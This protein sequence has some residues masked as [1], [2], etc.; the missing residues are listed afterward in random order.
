[1]IRN[2]LL[3]AYRNTIKTKLFSAINIFGLSIGMTA[4]LL[5]LHYVTFEKSYDKFHDNYQN[6][7]R[8]RYER[9]TETS[10]VRF[11][12]CCPPAAPIIRERYPE[13]KK[14]G[15]MVRNQATVS[16]GDKKMYEERMFYAEPEILEVLNFPFIEGDPIAGLK[17]PGNAVISEATSKRYFGSENPMGK[18][19]SVDKKTDYQIVGVF[20]DIPANSHIKF[21]ILLPWENLFK[22]LGTDYTEAWGHTGS[23]TYLALENGYSGAKFEKK[24]AGLVDELLGEAL[25]EYKMTL[26]LK[27]QPLADIHLTSNYLQEY[28]ANGNEDVVNILLIIA[29]FLI[30]MAWVNYI[31]LS[32]ARSLNRAKEVGLRKVVGASRTNLTIQFFVETALLNLISLVAAICLLYLTVPYFNSITGMASEI[33]IWSQSWFIPAIILLF[34]TG[35]ILSGFYPV[36][37]LS[38]FRPAVVLK[39]KFG[40]TA[41]GSRLRKGLVVF[42]FAIAFILITGTLTVFRQISFMQNQDLGFDTE[43]IL[44]LRAP[45]VRNENYGEKLKTFKEQL[46]RTTAIEKVSSVTEVPGRQIYWDAGAIRKQGENPNKGKNYMIVG[47]DYDFIDLFDMK[48]TSGRTFSRDF[49]SDKNAVMLN[50]TAV[51]FMGFDSPEEAVG[52]NIDY[53][54]NIYNIVGVVKDYH[55]QSLRDKFEPQIFRLMLTGR[56]VRGQIAVKMNVQNVKETVELVNK[57]FAEFFPG[58]PFEHFFLDEYYDQQYKSDRLLGDVVG[59]F[60]TL[61]IIITSLGIFGLSLFSA[62][63]RTKE[64]G[65]RKV[66]GAEVKN[67]LLILSKDFIVL[68]SI[69]FAIALPLLMYGLNIFLQS[70]AYRMELSVWLFLIPMLLVMTITLLTISYHIVKAAIT[71]PID[72]IRYE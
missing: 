15:R 69:S 46:E 9:A 8:L 67:I 13:V 22:K 20:K 58:N 3:T 71:N 49:P 59:T 37:A 14:I 21:D 47:V 42:Q 43:Q 33:S 35:I 72:T 55:Q 40:N 30:L 4:F 61:A 66:L 62:L 6:I 65:I 28:E 44:V 48:M 54:G 32:T 24:L 26:D 25:R 38:S 70:Y 41:K 52:K 11:A 7:Y 57:R 68:M 27:M 34:I 17:M 16:F 60:A 39:G 5:I 50:E 51:S 53:W 29:G 31:N 2:Y 36:I 12:S 56:D 18:T 19:I 63:Q 64:I 23:Y 45:R 10:A 1:M